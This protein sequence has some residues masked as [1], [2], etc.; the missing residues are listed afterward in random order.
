MGRTILRIPVTTISNRILIRTDPQQSRHT[1]GP[2]HCRH[3]H[4]LWPCYLPL[5]STCLKWNHIWKIKTHN[6]HN[7]TMWNFDGLLTYQTKCSHPL[8]CQRHV[9]NGR[10]QRLVSSTP[11]SQ[12]RA[13]AVYPLVWNDNN[14]QNGL[15]NVLC[16]MIKKVVASASEAETGGIYLS[17]IQC[18]PMWISCIELVHK[19]PPNGTPFETGNSTF[20]AILTSNMW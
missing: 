11:Q 5:Y 15:V 17:A 16:Q 10:I 2:K 6:R 12:S 14:K 20:H 1:T 9:P 4:I 19:E 18:C 8:S 7:N 13:A 3:F